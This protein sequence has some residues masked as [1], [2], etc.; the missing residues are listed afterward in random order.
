MA[1]HTLGEIAART[2]GRLFGDTA[3]RITGVAGIREA[4]PGDITFVANRRYERDVAT[5]GASALI[6]S[7]EISVPEGRSG[8][9]HANPS[10]A[11]AQVVELL[12]PSPARPEP[13][14]HAGAV[15]D[16]TASIGAD[17]S[18][19]PFVVVE[20]GAVVGTRTVLAP[21]VYV[22]AEARV[23]AD[24]LLYPHVSVRERCVL[25]DR[26]IAHCGAVI[27]SDGY[28]YVQI[29]TR[30]QKIPQTGIV[31]I[32]DDVEIGANVCIDRARFDRT[33]IGRGT[34]IDNLVQVAHNVR[35][36]EDC[37]LIAQAG[38]AGSAEIGKSAVL[39]GQSGVAGH[40]R[41]GD[42]AIVTG[43]AGAT[44]NVP[45]GAVVS[46]MPAR[47]HAQHLR[48]LAAL[49]EI[50]VWMRTVRAL[51]Q[52]VADLEKALYRSGE[53]PESTT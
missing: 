42:G 10:L 34:K 23:G 8:I 32:G 52:R 25:G 26:V 2:G 4:G 30:H 12:F 53:T 44:K 49:D 29:G 6:V 11:F 28:G 38:I 43:Q 7:E 17:V 47:P 50:E 39:A 45:A 40:I 33:I 5:T 21:F 41:I 20:A 36:G 19:G 35:V 18:I 27:G 48:T 15:V 13:G 1:A 16:P 22:G 24:C 46:G 31:E 3:C 51:E 9:V 14:V 37:L